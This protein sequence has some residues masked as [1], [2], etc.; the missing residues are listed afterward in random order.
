MV[1][2]PV[3]PETLRTRLREGITQFAFKKKDGTLRT[4]VG[5]T[6]LATIP[7]EAHPKGTGNPSNLSVRFYDM[8]KREWRS[9]SILQEIYLR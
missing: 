9:V 1:L 6:N 2:E 8:E 3:N 7:S 5:T 4:A